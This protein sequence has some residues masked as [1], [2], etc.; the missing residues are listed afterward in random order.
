MLVFRDHFNNTH[1]WK[2][3]LIFM[4]AIS[5]VFS[6]LVRYSCAL[7]EWR[8]LAF[9]AQLLRIEIKVELMLSIYQSKSE[10]SYRLSRSLWSFI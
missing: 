7:L 3:D 10:T 1:L 8:F 2:Y 9:R 4:A 5:Q 6:T